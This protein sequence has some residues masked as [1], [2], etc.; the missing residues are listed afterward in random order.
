MAVFQQ[1][2]IFFLLI[3]VGFYA[4]HK[5]MITSEN[6]AQISAI[7]VRI[8]YPAII[9]SGA[10][11]DGPRVGGSELLS[12]LGATI[13][14]L[15]LLFV[16]AW[17]LPRLL[18]Y[19]RSQH[20]IINTMTIFSNIG[21]M[22]V[23][24][25]DAI[26]GK[27]ALIY[28]TIFLIPFNLLFFSYAIQTIKGSG[29][30]QKLRL[31]DLLNEG[32]IACFLAII[33]YLADIRVPYVIAQTVAMLGSMTAPL[34]M[35][36]IGA[37]LSGMD[38]RGMF[39]DVRIWAFTALKMV[40]LPVAIVL[41]LGQFFDNRIL[42]A[43]CLA[44]IATPAGNVLAL[45]ASMYNEAAYPTAIKGITLTTIVSVATMPLVYYLTGLD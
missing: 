23:P 43:V 2:V 37:F 15:V 1:M 17:V 25:I 20:G 32:M 24:M 38:F 40:V 42:L 8:A 33:V 22:G 35:I 9:L 39:T 7:V 44:A 11:A 29:T 19:E 30:G 14:L 3:L 12:A 4:R 45:L 36:L 10:L 13:A 28:M 6:Q 41:A 26:Y 34:A 27:G 16:A 18:R 5:G 21:F 31:R